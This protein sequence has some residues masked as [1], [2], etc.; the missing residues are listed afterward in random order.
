MSTQL[1]HLDHWYAIID[2]ATGE[3]IRIETQSGEVITQEEAPDYILIEGDNQNY[4]GKYYLN[5]AWYED[6]EGT[7]PWSPEE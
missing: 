5:G 7:I 1:E 4:R 2:L 6:A 3:C